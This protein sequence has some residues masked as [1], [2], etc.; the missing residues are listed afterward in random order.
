A[1]PSGGQGAAR[2][3]PLPR[4]YAADAARRAPRA[5]RGSPLRP[6]SEAGAAQRTSRQLTMSSL[7][8]ATGSQGRRGPSLPRPGR[9]A[10][11]N[12][13]SCSSSLVSTGTTR[14]RNMAGVDISLQLHVNASPSA[15]QEQ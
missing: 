7:R 12:A 8:D 11:A 9:L 1:A 10:A 15:N 4:R 5:T 6:A 14:A 3:P 13:S 2:D